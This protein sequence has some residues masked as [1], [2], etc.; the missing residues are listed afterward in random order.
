MPMPLASP[1]IAARREGTATY[2][3]EPC[4][5]TGQSICLLVV[6]VVPRGPGSLLIDPILTMV[7]LGRD[8]RLDTTVIVV[9]ARPGTAR[10]TATTTA[11]RSIATETRDVCLAN[12]DRTSRRFRRTAKTSNE[13]RRAG[14]RRSSTRPVV[15]VVDIRAITAA[16]GADEGEVGVATTAVT[17]GGIVTISATVVTVLH[18]ATSAVAKEIENG[19]IGIGRVTGA[20]GLHHLAGEAGRHPAVNSTGSEMVHPA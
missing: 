16:E 18:S 2:I 20:G 1:S 8:T 15:Y 4:P 11:A 9:R 6:R 13:S 7:L 12:R 19:Q 17:G 3:P 14:L 10:L 5:T